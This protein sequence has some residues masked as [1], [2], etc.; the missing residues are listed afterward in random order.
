MT[1][2]EVAKYPRLHPRC[3]TSFLFIV[4][5]TSVVVFSLV[6]SDNLVMRIV[7]RVLLI[8]VLAGLSFEV[9]LLSNKYRDSAVI[10]LLTVPGMAFQ[11]LTT[12]E[13]EP[14]MIEVAI[15]ALDEVRRLEEAQGG[16][17]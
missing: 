16:E 10:R 17:S 4:V 13:P 9:L 14:D 5:L 6:P 8:P 7:Y 1:V 12:K 15:R 11:R 2:E 3:G